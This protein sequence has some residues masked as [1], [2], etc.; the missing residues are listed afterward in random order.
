MNQ[1][2][3]M[4]IWYQQNKEAQKKK[5]LQ[6]HYKNRNKALKRM[7]NYNNKNKR[8]LNKKAMEH[9]FKNKE[10]RD[11]KHKLWRLKNLE[12]DKQ[13][14]REYYYKNRKRMVTLSVQYCKKR[15]KIDA[16]Y[17]LRTILIARFCYVITKHKSSKWEKYLGCNIKTAREHLE[18]LFKPGMTWL[19]HGKWHID[20]IR[21]VSSFNLTNEK[22][23]YECFYYKN[24]QPL[25]ARENL[26]K[27]AKYTEQQASN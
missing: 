5:S 27:G 25:W 14:S 7:V 21:P 9:Y 10:D 17:K 15:K 3:Y 16:E 23:I 19:N 20:H 13:R 18:S 26:S 8:T 24:L 4:Q 22:H 11:K 12:Y 1:K 2:K 6:Y